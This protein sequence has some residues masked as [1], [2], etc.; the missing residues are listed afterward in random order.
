M[1]CSIDWEILRTS[2]LLSSMSRA[3]TARGRLSPCW[4]AMAEAAGLAVHRYTS[5]HLVRFHER[6][7]LAGN[8]IGDDA[9]TRVLST[10]LDANGDAPI[11][12]FEATTAAAFLAM[13][14]VPADM[15]LLETGLG[16]RLDATNV[17]KRPAATVLTA[18]DRDHMEFLGD[19]LSAI[20]KEKAAIMR[21]GIPCIAAAQQPEVA[22]VITETAGRIGAPLLL[23]DRDWR[24][25]ETAEGIAFTPGRDQ[26]RRHFPNPDLIGRHQIDN[27]GIALAVSEVLAARFPT[28]TDIARADGLAKAFM[29]ARLQPL[30]HG[31]LVE[32]LKRGWEL[33]LDGGHNAAAAAAIAAQ[34][35]RPAAVRG[36]GGQPLDLILGLMRRKEADTYLARLAPVARHIATVTIPGDDGSLDAGTLAEKACAAGMKAWPA[37]S[38]VEAL[39]QLQNASADPAR[40]L[41]CGSLYL[42]GHVLADH[43]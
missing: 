3:P 5:P 38:V 20:A 1:P 13:A 8:E 40:V 12:F 33:W 28:L 14:E 11:T 43:G 37:T 32:R 16:G 18:I 6:I 2:C 25:E 30:R 41:I 27:A 24:V 34:A 31:P 17:I 23:Q 42:A 21:A 36:W 9:L 19:S 35:T 4:A 7:R 26:G 15:V 29:P 39:D 10:V 22:E